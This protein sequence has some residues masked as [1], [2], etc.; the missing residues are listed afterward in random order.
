MRRETEQPAHDKMSSNL[1]TSIPDDDGFRLPRIGEPLKRAVPGKTAV[2]PTERFEAN[3]EAWLQPGK[4]FVPERGGTFTAVLVRHGSEGR[5]N[6][7]LSYLSFPNAATT[8]SAAV[9]FTM[10]LT[11]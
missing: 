6:G 8:F 2:P 11:S 9:T 5:M 4:L 7:R 1:L 10:L 3:E